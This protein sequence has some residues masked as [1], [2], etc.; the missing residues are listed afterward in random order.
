MGDYH[1]GE[2]KKNWGTQRALIFYLIVMEEGFN[3]H[4]LFMKILPYY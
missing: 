4:C 3:T 2:K 1:Y